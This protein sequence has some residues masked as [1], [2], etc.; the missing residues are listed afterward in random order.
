MHNGEH[1][2]SITGSPLYM[3]PEI[4]QRKYDTRVDIWS[5]GVLLYVILSLKV[6]FG[7]KDD[8]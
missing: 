2:S 1:M 5:M 4:L 6:P 8:E 3:A 7:G